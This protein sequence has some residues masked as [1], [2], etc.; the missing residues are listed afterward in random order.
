MEEGIQ[1][2]VSCLNL[3]VDT[4]W[5]ECSLNKSGP[6]LTSPALEKGGTYLVIVSGDVVVDNR[7]DWS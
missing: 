3:H 5:L 2:C 6:A 4:R 1:S 7:T